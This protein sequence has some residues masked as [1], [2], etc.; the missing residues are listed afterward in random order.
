MNIKGV[1]SALWLL[2]LLSAVALTGLARVDPG[3]KR[4]TPTQNA[5]QAA[6]A[7]YV[8]MSDGR[9]GV[10]DADGHVVPVGAYSRIGSNST[11]AD[12]L[13]LA[14]VEPERIVSLSDYG[15]KNAEEPHRWGKR[16]VTVELS[17]LEDLLAQKPDLLVVNHMGSEAQLARARE[18]GIV[19]FNLGEM[20]GLAT[21]LPNIRA[22]S[23]LLGVPERGERYAVK[24][25]TTHAPSGQRRS[26]CRAKAGPLRERLRQ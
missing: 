14:L 12:D 24:L 11:V 20:R 13:V 1:L 2:A 3:S 18:A 6:S 19:V 15:R 23:A 22:V 16:P 10:A 17:N 21:L 26:P 25:D 8:T 9:Q 5:A 7:N 4:R